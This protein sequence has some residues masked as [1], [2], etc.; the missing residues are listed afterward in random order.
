MVTDKAGLKAGQ[1]FRVYLPSEDLDTYFL[2]KSV[3][4]EDITAE[5]MRYTVNMT[6]VGRS[7][8]GL[9]GLVKFRTDMERAKT[10]G[11]WYTGFHH[12]FADEHVIC[13]D[14]CSVKLGSPG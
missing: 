6:N 10:E 7:L 3:T 5:T 13:K 2:I 14:S 9:E 12:A 8:Q 1:V 4:G 11:K